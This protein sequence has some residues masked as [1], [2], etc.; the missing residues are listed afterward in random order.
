MLKKEELLEIF[1]VGGILCLITAI[2]A[3]ALAATNAK[4]APLI[5]QHEQEKQEAA[6]KVVLPDADGFDSEN[7][8]ND[9]MEEIV[10][11]VYAAKDQSGYAVMVSPNGYGGAISLA[12][13]VSADGTVTGLDVISQ[14][15]TAGLGANCTKESFREQF[16]G[17]TEGITVTKNGASGNQINA[18]SSATITSKAVTS[19]VNA[20]I[21]AV[22]EVKTHE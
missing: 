21:L 9:S 22:K 10:T 8:K 12:V 6:M 4:T 2:A 19:G 14:S 18:I 7:L 5:A 17:K 20:A 16:T 3:L 13:G 15:E 11:A 1:K